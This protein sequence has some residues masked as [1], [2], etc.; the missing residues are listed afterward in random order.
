MK[1]IFEATIIARISYE[2]KKFLGLISE[3]INLD[4]Y[5]GFP[6]DILAPDEKSARVIVKSSDFWKNDHLR[7][8]IENEYNLEGI[9]YTIEE[10]IL[11]VSEIGSASMFHLMDNM[12]FQD[13]IEYMKEVMVESKV[14]L[15]KI[16]LDK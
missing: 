4:H 16:A 15:P 5:I 3:E 8:S 13:F 12:R 10:K 7:Y 11:I 6:Y 14:K 9:T 2:K 1:K